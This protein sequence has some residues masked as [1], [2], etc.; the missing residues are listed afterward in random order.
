M[1][2]RYI[3]NCNCFAIQDISSVKSAPKSKSQR[4]EYTE[5]AKVSLT[6][7]HAQHHVYGVIIDAT[8]PYK[9]AD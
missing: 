6:D 7:T 5:L 4:Y 3:R 9:V 2:E 1:I 8:F